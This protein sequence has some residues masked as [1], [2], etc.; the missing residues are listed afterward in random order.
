MAFFGIRNQVRG[1]PP[2]SF[3]SSAVSTEMISANTNRKALFMK[4]ASLSKVYLA[5]N[6][7][8]AVV[9]KGDAIERGESLQNAATLL[10]IES[11]NV[12]SEVGM[13][14]TIEFQ[15]WL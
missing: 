7:H 8:D 12:I 5:F 10:P 1:Q 3:E 4:N 2:E 14:G 9:G 15:E 6:G 11:I 13:G